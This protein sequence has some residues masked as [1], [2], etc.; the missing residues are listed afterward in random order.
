MEEPSK[1]RLVILKTVT[2][3]P[4]LTWSFNNGG[5]VTTITTNFTI[6]T[7]I[8][9]SADRVITEFKISQVKITENGV[10]VNLSGHKIKAIKVMLGS[11]TKIGYLEKVGVNGIYTAAQSPVY[12]NFD[13]SVAIKAG[14]SIGIRP[15]YT[16]AAYS[17]GLMV[18]VDAYRLALEAKKGSSY[19]ELSK[20]G[21]YITTTSL[22]KNPYVGKNFSA[23]YQFTL[24]SGVSTKVFTYNSS[25]MHTTLKSGTN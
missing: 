12:L 2:L 10:V 9:Q 16:S 1:E 15:L 3:N 14:V 5:D 7:K 23:Q 21:H 20:A 25:S 11:D 6:P 24:V 4:S 13:S 17:N 8:S 22:M 18:P 19:L